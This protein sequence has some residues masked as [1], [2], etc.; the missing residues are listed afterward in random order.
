MHLSQSGCRQSPEG[1]GLLLK[2]WE[3]RGTKRWKQGELT[4]SLPEGSAGRP[5]S[6]A[7]CV[8]VVQ[9]FCSD[10]DWDQN[11]GLLCSQTGSSVC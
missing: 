10:T 9:V 7:F 3:V 11:L 4:G 6:P 2:H 1:G 8:P 5:T